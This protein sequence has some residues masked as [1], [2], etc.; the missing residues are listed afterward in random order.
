MRHQVVEE[1]SVRQLSIAEL[2]LVTGAVEVEADGYGNVVVSPDSPEN[3]LHYIGE[4]G[5][6][7]QF[8]NED[9]WEEGT[10]WGAEFFTGYW[11]GGG[12]FEVYQWYD[13]EYHL[14]DTGYGGSG[15]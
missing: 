1:K 10:I 11:S 3:G 15:Y 4:S 13:S 2:E 12:F 14:Y 7:S 8:T 6:Y 5:N 9:Y